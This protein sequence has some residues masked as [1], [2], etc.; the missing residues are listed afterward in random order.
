MANKVKFG[1]RNVYYAKETNTGGTITYAT[2]VKIE[3]AVSL[4]LEPAGDTTPFYADDTA[5]FV[6]SA[7]NGYSGELNIAMIPDSFKKDILGMSEDSNGA[8]IEN[9][10]DKIHEFALGFEVQGDDKPR[11][12]W[13]YHCT[14]SRAKDEAKTTEA[15]VEPSTDTLTITAMPRTSDYAVKVV[16]TKNSQNESAF[17]SFFSTVYER[18]ASV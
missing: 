6:A 14:V 16:M 7:N 1:L 8:L 10:D 3:G 11:R 15:S 4:S 13:L 9:A 2:P 18:T 17:N 12:T 5:F